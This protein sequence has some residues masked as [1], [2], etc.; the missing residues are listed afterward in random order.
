MSIEIR[1]VTTNDTGKEFYDMLQTIEEEHSY[2]HGTLGTP[3]E[4]FPRWLIH[5]VKI[6][7]GNVRPLSTYWFLNDGMPIGIG[8]FHHELTDELRKSGGNIVYCIAP[9]YRGKGY[10]AEAVRL[11]TEKMREF[12]IPEI[13]FTIKKDNIP[14]LR[15]A[16]K[17]GAKTTSEND[18]IYYLTVR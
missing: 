7:E 3:Y 16:E 15:C 8:R 5:C 6:A 11:L 18:S 10:G 2:M 12:G 1:K 17:C 14:S 9:Q 4:I 13:L